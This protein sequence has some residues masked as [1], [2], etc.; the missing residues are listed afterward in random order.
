MKKILHLER[1]AVLAFILLTGMFCNAQPVLTENF[2]YAN[3]TLLTAAGWSA[4]SGPG[5]QAVDVVVPGLSFTGYGLSNIGGAARI[6]NNG[7]DVNRTFAVQSS[8]TVYAAF[9]VNVA[10]LVDGYFLHLGGDPISTIFRA[11]LFTAGTADPFNFGISVGANT[12][13]TVSGGA[14]NLNK[15]YLLVIKYEVIDGTTNDK[16]SLF[17]FS[18]AIPATEPATPSVGPLTDAT[19]SD[20]NPGSIALRQFSASQNILVDGI[21]IGKTWAEAVTTTSTADVTPP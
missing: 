8:G 17:V 6:D 12:A 19:M 21:R 10:S 16:V 1:L 11:K 7:E 4:H 20:I 2:D 14:F 9:L 13:T 18:G 3:G 5:T 15:T